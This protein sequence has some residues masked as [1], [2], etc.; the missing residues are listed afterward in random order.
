MEVVT[1]RR[2]PGDCI[3]FLR[4]ELLYTSPARTDPRPQ[5]FT[6]SVRHAPHLPVGTRAAVEQRFTYTSR[7]IAGLAVA[8]LGKALTIRRVRE[9]VA[10]CGGG[11]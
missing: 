8:A 4:P 5:R 1:S 10:A 3:L 6:Q 7:E 11:G 2:P 9:V